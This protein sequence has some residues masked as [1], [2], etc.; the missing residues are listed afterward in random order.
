MTLKAL[1]F[2]VDGTLAETEEVHRAAFNA[3]FR[4]A[5]LGW[6]WDRATYGNLLT[7]T[8]GKERMARFREESGQALMD[9]TSLAALHK[10][11]TTFY[12]KMIAAGSLQLRPGV[13]NLIGAAR[14]RGLKLAL[15]TTTSP[16]NVEALCLS[17][18]QRRPD[19]I[20]DAVAAGDEVPAKKPAPD[21]FLLALD[22]LGL[23]AGSALA[24]EDSR[25]GLRAATAAG[26]RTIITP[27]LYTEQE[28][29]DGALAVHPTLASFNLGAFLTMA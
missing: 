13:A 28:T 4:E 6:H 23:P 8:G 1:I 15:A 19:Q 21:V 9:K 7:T 25:N 27:S 10:S 22:R 20:F 16:Q 2:D 26:L 17:I 12:I 11:K 24:F 29:F 14:A 18:W 5:G 3:A